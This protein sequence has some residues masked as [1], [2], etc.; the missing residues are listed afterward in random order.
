MCKLAD[1]QPLWFWWDQAITQNN[2][3]FTVYIP[4]EGLR[5]CD[6]W[7]AQW[8]SFGSSFCFCLGTLSGI[9]KENPE[10]VALLQAGIHSSALGGTKRTSVGAV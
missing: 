6:E 7:E 9:S 8:E 10:I 4:W 3:D 2:K 5:K 1:H